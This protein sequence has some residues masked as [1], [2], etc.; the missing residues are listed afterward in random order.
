[1]IKNSYL[2]KFIVLEG[3]DGSGASTQVE[4]VG[5]YLQGR[6]IS[7]VLGKEPTNEYE[8]GKEIRRILRGERKVTPRELQELFAKDRG[9]HLEKSI[10]P[11][12]KEGKWV[13]SD[14]YFFSSLAF[15]S[16]DG[17]DL[18]WLIEINSKFI[19]PDQTFILKV[20]PRVCIERINKRGIK[21]ELFEKEE[22]L[23]RVWQTYE[24]LPSM[25]DNVEI[26]GGEIAPAEVFESIRKILNKII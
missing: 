9:E 24:K 21:K 22:K 7:A 5:G 15:G 3:L 14:R 1:M 11:A 6:A 16:C 25:F 2:G 17:L 18:E 4:L 20:N 19:L 26:I 10:I 13:V 23:A 8:E 12:L